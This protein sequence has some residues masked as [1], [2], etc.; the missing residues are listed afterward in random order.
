MPDRDMPPLDHRLPS[1]RAP[2]FDARRAVIRAQAA[3]LF[4]RDGYQRASL[5]GLAR[6]LGVTANGIS[7]YYSSKEDLLYAILDSHLVALLA[8]VERADDET[9]APRPRLEALA[10]GYLTTIAGPAANGHRL[11]REAA[12]FLPE[13]R[14]E[15][16]RTRERWLLALFSTALAAAAPRCAAALLSPLALS[17]FAM[18]NEAPRWLQPRDEAAEALSLAAYAS[19]ATRAV[20]AAAR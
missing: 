16:L 8:A 12:R 7:N 18:L 10:G 9:L 11:L 6:S 17:L 19:L 14:R 20:L 3:A 13:A 4:A 15:D 1:R 2:G 5:A